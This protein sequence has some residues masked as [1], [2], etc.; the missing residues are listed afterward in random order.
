MSVPLRLLL[1]ICEQKVFNINKVIMLGIFICTILKAF[2]K[3][4]GQT[5]KVVQSR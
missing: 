1:S 2:L 5:W 3:K 4:S